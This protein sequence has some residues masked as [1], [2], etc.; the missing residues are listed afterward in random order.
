VS[1]KYN[2]VSSHQGTFKP[3]KQ[4]V[5]LVILG[6]SPGRFTLAIYYLQVKEPY[7]LVQ[8]IN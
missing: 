5:A 4:N 8:A 7:Y 2:Y 1:K 3:L 6:E